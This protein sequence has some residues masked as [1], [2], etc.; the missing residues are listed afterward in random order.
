MCTGPVQVH[1]YMCCLLFQCIMAVL[2]PLSIERR[3]IA[4][5]TSYTTGLTTSKQSLAAVSGPSTSST[6][7][8]Y[9]LSVLWLMY[10]VYIF[11]EPEKEAK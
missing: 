8:N 9:H 1:V 11:R 5:P 7:I 2:V 6:G 10:Y 4:T 3:E